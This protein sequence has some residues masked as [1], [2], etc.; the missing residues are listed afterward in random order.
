MLEPKY[1]T[2]RVF[3]NEQGTMTRYEWEEPGAAGLN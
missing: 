2:V 3:I 1:K